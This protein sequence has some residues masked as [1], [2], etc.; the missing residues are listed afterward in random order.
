ML[1]KLDI[2]YG[3]ETTGVGKAGDT[4][5]SVV[6]WSMIKASSF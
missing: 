2:V 3:S 5:S 4:Y 6:S 1:W